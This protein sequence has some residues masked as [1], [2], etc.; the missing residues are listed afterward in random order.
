VRG[1]LSSSTERAGADEA[2][3]DTATLVDFTGAKAISAVS[4]LR[5]KQ[6]RSPACA[7]DPVAQRLG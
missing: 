2:N 5:T 3:D 7:S 1:A 4:T 6:A